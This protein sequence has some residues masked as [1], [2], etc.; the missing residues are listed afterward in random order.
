MREQCPADQFASDGRDAS[1][2]SSS[3]S[4]FDEINKPL[5]QVSTTDQ[6]EWVL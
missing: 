3:I 5:T 1:H 4:G 2:F 6:A